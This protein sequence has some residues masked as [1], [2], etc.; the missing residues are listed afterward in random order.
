MNCFIRYS[1]VKFFLTCLAMLSLPV[2]VRAQCT[3]ITGKNIY[4]LDQIVRLKN[5]PYRQNSQDPSQMLDLYFAA[6]AVP[7][8][9]VKLVLLIHGGGFEGGTKDQLKSWGYYFAMK[10]YYAA[11]INYRFYLNTKKE[12]EEFLWNPF[13]FFGDG[14]VNNGDDD[15]QCSKLN[16]FNLLDGIYNIDKAWY[17]AIQDSR[18]ALAYLQYELEKQN[19]QLKQ[20]YAVGES[21]GA[22]TA[23]GLALGQQDDFNA[24]NPMLGENFGTIDA[25]VMH[26]NENPKGIDAVVSIS[27]GMINAAEFLS[28]ED[29]I[30][31]LFFHGDSDEIIPICNDFCYN[32]ERRLI[33]PLRMAELADSLELSINVESHFWADKGHNLAS[34]Y[35]AISE[36]TMDWLQQLEK[37]NKGQRNNDLYVYP[38]SEFL[39]DCETVNLLSEFVLLGRIIATQQQQQLLAVKFKIYPNPSRGRFTIQ[40]PNMSGELLNIEIYDLMGNLTFSQQAIAMWE[41]VNVDAQHLRPGIY[42]VVVTSSILG[43]NKLRLVIQ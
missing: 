41:E 25:R 13:I 6:P 11:A 21:A 32:Q 36:H 3:E 16:G 29:S 5:Q 12:L 27:G 23:L 14:P 39:Y 19:K 31:L 26:P 20:V 33:G 22:I 43:A 18:A 15:S 2:F 17:F 34:Q 42:E 38:P 28:E 30:P 35:P 4:R 1:M 8:K 10:G 40:A 24:Y 7:C 37:K 9:E